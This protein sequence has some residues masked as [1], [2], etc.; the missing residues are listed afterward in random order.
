MSKN[1]EKKLPK[2][3]ENFFGQTVFGFW[4][5]IIRATYTEKMKKIVSAVLEIFEVRF[6]NF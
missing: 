6:W 4:K 5:T 3:I 1:E 2:K